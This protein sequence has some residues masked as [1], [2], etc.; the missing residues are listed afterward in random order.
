MPDLS[1]YSSVDKAARILRTVK[2]TAVLQ[3]AV[4]S[5]TVAGVLTV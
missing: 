1:T 2:F 4:H 5:V 3:G